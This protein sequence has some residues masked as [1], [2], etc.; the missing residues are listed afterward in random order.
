MEV[1]LGKLP[2]HL[3]LLHG[4]LYGTGIVLE[5]CAAARP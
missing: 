1:S 4:K 3:A 5:F 2:R